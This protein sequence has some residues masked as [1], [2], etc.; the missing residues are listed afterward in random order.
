MSV[1][2]ISG[3]IGAGAR[4]VCRLVAGRLNLEYVD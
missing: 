1:L 4:E 3:Q 2:T